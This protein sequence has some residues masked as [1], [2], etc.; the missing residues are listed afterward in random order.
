VSQQ[1]LEDPERLELQIQQVPEDLIL[2]HLED[3][4]I[5]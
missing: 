2:L 3:L 4:E 5:Q 1:F